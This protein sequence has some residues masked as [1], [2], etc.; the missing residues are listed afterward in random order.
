[1]NMQGS[2]E[3]K[4]LVDSN[5]YNRAAVTSCGNRQTSVDL[6]VVDG[7]SSHYVQGNEMKNALAKRNWNGVS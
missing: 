2:P 7:M 6:E 4:D 3:P 5:G 1:M